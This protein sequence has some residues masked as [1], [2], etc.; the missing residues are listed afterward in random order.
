MAGH[1][2]AFINE[3]KSNPKTLKIAIAKTPVQPSQND[4]SLH[5]TTTLITL[6]LAKAITAGHNNRYQLNREDL[7]A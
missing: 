4:C 5:E 1:A 7:Y 6:L 3:L 2:D